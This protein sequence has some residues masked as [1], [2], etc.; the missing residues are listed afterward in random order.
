LSGADLRANLFAGV[1]F[2]GASLAGADLRYCGFRQC[3]FTDADMTGAKLTRK[4]GTV[5]KLSAEQQQSIDWQA[6]DG[7]EPPGGL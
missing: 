4:A 3:V 1:R 5:M 6:E 7:E 2:T